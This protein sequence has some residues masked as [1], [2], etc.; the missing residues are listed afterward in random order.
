MSF[1]KSIVKHGL[2]QEGIGKVLR[3]VTLSSVRKA[4]PDRAIRE[5]CEGAAYEYRERLIVPVVVVLHMVMAA[6][7]PENSFAASWR[8][9]WSRLA[10]VLP[11]AAGKSPGSGTVS[12]ARNRVPLKVWEHLFGWLAER[13]G[14]QAGDLDRWRGLRLVLVDGAIISMAAKPEL[15]EAFD[16]GR[17]KHGFFRYPVGRVVTL[18]LANSMGIIAYKLGGYLTSEKQ[19]LRDLL[20]RLTS[21]DLLIGDRGFAAANLYVEYL[22]AGVQFVTRAHQCLKLGRLPRLKSF[23]SDDFITN[24]KITPANRRTNPALPKFVT[25]RIIRVEARV[26]GQYKAIW[27]ATSLLDAK[28]Y[29]AREI[30]GMYLRRWRIETLFGELKIGMGAGVLRS[31]TPDGVR[32]ELAARIIATNIVHSIMLEA[33][34]TQGLDPTRISFINAVRTMLC[35]AATMADSP[36]RRLP[37]IYDAMLKE[38]ASSLVPERP[39]RN[40]PRAIRRERKNYASLRC[41]RAEW[42]RRQ[43]A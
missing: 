29:P 43:R 21:G 9:V 18:A 15:F 6:L 40:E 3:S 24:L 5:A 37:A 1:K 26:R 14:K 30:A 22:S 28:I 12:K 4:L 13:F 2:E 41:T 35:F 10:S 32:K 33:A 17:G 20:G 38:V 42:H 25:A 23:S 8:M 7:W 31:E 27:L 36:V 11:S 34:E 39:N 19:L 16:R